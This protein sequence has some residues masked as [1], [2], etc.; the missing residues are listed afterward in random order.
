MKNNKPVPDAENT[1]PSPAEAGGDSMKNTFLQA[2]KELSRQLMQGKTERLGFFETLH[3]KLLGRADGRLG[4][5]RPA[6]SGAWTSSLILKEIDAYEEHCEKIWGD[7]QL[8]LHESYS[9]REGLLDL[10]LRLRAEIKAEKEREEAVLPPDAKKHG[11]EDL[12]AEL[13]R[14]RRKREADRVR[15]RK[16]EKLAALRAQYTTALGELSDLHRSILE[17]DYGARHACQR[18]MSHTLR[19]I[20]VYWRSALRVHPEGAGMPAG[21]G[22]LAAPRAET[23]YFTDHRQ[24]NERTERLLAQQEADDTFGEFPREAA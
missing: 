12:P 21:I 8:R 16:Q 7:L 1:R 17:A 19:R 20:E 24:Q 13:I 5:P 18:I 9:R 11:E 15:A 4:I 14:A 3:M 6:E 2:D 22:P 10:L 23:A